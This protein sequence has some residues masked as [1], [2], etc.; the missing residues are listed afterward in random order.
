MKIVGLPREIKSGEGRVGLTPLGVQK[1][2]QAGVCV[3]VEQGLGLISG[4]SDS[5][6]QNAGAVIRPQARQ[7][8][9]EADLIVKVKEPQVSEL[10][11]FKKGKTLF[12]FLHLA[13]DGN[14]LIAKRLK[15]SG[16]QAIA[17]EGVSLKGRT[18]LLQPMSQIAGDVAGYF[19]GIIRHGTRIQKGKLL[20]NSRYEA[21]LDR[22]RSTYPQAPDD[23]NPGKVLVLGAG[24][25]GTHAIEMVLRMGG[26][27][28]VVDAS[29]A[30]RKKLVRRCQRKGFAIKTFSLAEPWKDYLL[31]AD[32]IVGAIYVLNQRTPLLVDAKTLEGASRKKK[33]CIVDVSVDQGGSLFGSKPTSYEKPIYLDRWGNRRFG[34]SNIPALVSR[35]SSQAL[36]KA[37]LPYVLALASEKSPFKKYPEL[38]SGFC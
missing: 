13:A 7:I 35:K 3:L 8:W 14:E 29:E 18:I 36:E 11:Y 6:Y 32:A 5:Q 12:A 9:D 2:Y 38:C 33:K 25:V 34:V 10:K 16:M 26:E 24:Q 31:Q 15:S 19:T 27:V 20:Y 22:L 4:Y 21:F 17:Y 30:Q 1:L 37:T 23:L 28:A